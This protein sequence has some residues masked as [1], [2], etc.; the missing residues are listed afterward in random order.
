MKIRMVLV[1]TVTCA[2]CSSLLYWVYGVTNPKIEADIARKLKVNLMEVM[3]PGA[4]EYKAS[5]KD[6]TLWEAYDTT[7]KIV[8]IAYF[9]SVVADTVWIVFDTCGNK[10][11]IVFKVCPRGYGGPIPTLVGLSMDTTVTGIRTATPPEGLKETPGLGTKV[12]DTWFKRQFI[13]KREQE[14]LLKKDGGKLDAI[15]AATISSRAVTDG[16]RKGVKKYKKYLE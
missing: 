12:N 7:D 16:V 14:I 11:G 13:G 4:K 9:K 6:T 2:V 15:T 10:I 8:G 5:A 3:F 1:L